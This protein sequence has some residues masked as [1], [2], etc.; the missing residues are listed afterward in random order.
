MKISAYQHQNNYISQKRVNF[1]SHPDLA[2]LKKKYPEQ[3]NVSCYFRHG[4]FALPADEYKRIITSIDDI[5]K[6]LSN[7]KTMLIAGVGDS[8]EPFS[9]LAA[10]KSITKK[11]LDE[12]VDLYIVDI[13]DKPGDDIL[14]QQSYYDG[15]DSPPFAKDSFVATNKYRKLFGLEPKYRV[16]DEIYEYLKKTYSNP[17]KSK[18]GTRVQDAMK[19]YPNEKFNIISINN[20]LTYIDNI[21]IIESTL[22]NIVRTMKPKGVF[23]TDTFET[24]KDTL[25]STKKVDWLDHGIFTK[26]EKG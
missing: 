16:K 19:E 18:W 24:T 10:I 9:H 26:R 21:N 11:P 7:K 20:V 23:F 15:I 13:K 8:Q 2:L 4:I 12:V 17:Q 3:Y 25:L 1:K 14:F 5:F 6:S 22:K